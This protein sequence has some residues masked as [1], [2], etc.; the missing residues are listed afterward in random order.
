MKHT[1]ER[2]EPGFYKLRGTGIEIRNVQG[3]SVRFT[4]LITDPWRVHDGGP[5]VDLD[6]QPSFVTMVEAKAYALSLVKE[7]KP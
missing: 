4:G 5:W 3:M 7:V 2:V 6:V 1:W